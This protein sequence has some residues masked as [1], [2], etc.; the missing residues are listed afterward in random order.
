MVY[1]G[2]FNIQLSFLREKENTLKMK[3]QKTLFGISA[4]ILGLSAL[5]GAGLFIAES[6]RPV[7]AGTQTYHFDH[8]YVGSSANPFGVSSDRFQVYIPEEAYNL[9]VTVIGGG[10]AGGGSSDGTSGPAVTGGGGGS[11]YVMAD[12]APDSANVN[13]GGFNTIFVGTGGGGSTCASGGYGP[14]C[15]GLNGAASSAFGITAAGGQGGI[16]DGAGTGGSGRNSGSNGI[17]FSSPS[18]IPFTT[19][20]FSDKQITYYPG[21]PGG[22][23]YHLTNNYANLGAGGN[24]VSILIGNISGASELFYHDQS[25]GVFWD[26]GV[27]S[28]G[29][30]G[31]VRIQ[32][33]I[34]DF[35]YDPKITSV[36]PSFGPTAGG[37]TVTIRGI[38][39]DGTESVMLGNAPCVNINIISSTEITC[40]TTAHDAGLAGITLTSHGITLQHFGVYIYSDG[41]GAD[42]ACEVPYIGENGNWWIGD[43]D[44]GVRAEGRDGKDGLTPRIGENGNWWIGDHDTGVSVAGSGNGSVG[45]PDTNG[46]APNAPKTG[47][48]PRLASAKLGAMAGAFAGTLIAAGYMLRKK[49]ARKQ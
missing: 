10:G 19:V 1:F 23:G 33:S 41:G 15:S 30:T 49:F 43:T 20:D 35:A 8:I 36:S 3:Q 38:D 4:T 12:V 6:A 13:Y 25:T 48:N 9:S 44:T 22:L 47:L 31:A 46:N 29:V 32:Y 5:C 26:A 37:E 16:G 34:D 2:D 24:G 28:N 7:E 14:R 17:V 39:L 42:C 21:V 40:V 11:G 45:V 18:D 27:S